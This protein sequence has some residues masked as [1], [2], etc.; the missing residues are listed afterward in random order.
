MSFTCN[1][2][3]TDRINRAIIGVILCIAALF[4]MGKFYYFT[5]GFA[6]IIE[7]IIGWCSI[8]FALG[9]IKRLFNIRPI[10]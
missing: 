5:L 9:K 2:D 4:E 1:I 7:G 6:L 8:P 3:K 10:K